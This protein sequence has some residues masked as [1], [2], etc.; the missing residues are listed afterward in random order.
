MVSYIPF[1]VVYMNIYDMNL[2]KFFKSIVKKYLTNK[3][4]FW[5]K[6]NHSK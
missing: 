6:Y 3:N 1:S 4:F 5:G 2:K